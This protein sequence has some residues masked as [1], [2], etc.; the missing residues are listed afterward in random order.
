[1]SVLADE[2][3]SRRQHTPSRLLRLLSL[4]QT[5]REWSGAELAAKL[6]VTDRT[7]RRDI[8]RLRALDYPVASA[9]GTA[10]GYRLTSGRDLPPLQLDDDEVVAVALGLVTVASTSVTGI[11]DNA[12]TALA[13]LERGLPNRLRPRLAALGRSALAVPLREA[14]GVDP[15]VLAVLASCC[16]D[17]EIVTFDYHARDGSRSARRVEPHHL[18]TVRGHWYLLAYDLRR[19][20]WRSFRADRLGCLTPV[21]HRFVPRAL[22]APDP[23]TYLRRS[24]A[25]A[26]YAHN[27]R[28]AV[29][30]PADDVRQRVFTTVPGEIEPAGPNACTVRLSAESVDLVAQYVVVIMALDTEVTLVD[31]SPEVA[32]RLRAVRRK[33]PE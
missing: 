5:R 7:V 14:P 4:L 27:A 31:V 18:I 16:R 1:M 17:R 19:H 12:M 24:F 20:G 9:P 32:R 23:A 15:A 28:L 11:A 10:G 13:T 8:D 25:A 22:P 3:G 2:P 33:L 26:E 29:A 30:L 21:R 6:G